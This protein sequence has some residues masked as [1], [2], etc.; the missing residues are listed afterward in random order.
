MGGFVIINMKTRYIFLICLFF[1]I[2]HG[3]P[4][5]ECVVEYIDG[6]LEMKQDNKWIEVEEGAILPLTAII[7]TH[8]NTLVELNLDQELYTISAKGIYNLHTIMTKSE[9]INSWNI[10]TMIEKK[11]ALMIEDDMTQYEATMGV[12][13]DETTDPDDIDWMESSEYTVWEGQ[14]LIDAGEYEKALEYFH[15]AFLNAFDENEEN[16]YLFYIGYCYALLG[17]KIHALISLSKIDI[18]EDV[19]Y[20][21]HFILIKSRLLAESL[22]FQKAL[23]L[24]GTYFKKFPKG[25]YAQAL[26]FLCAYCFTETN[27]RKEAITHLKRAYELDPHSPIGREAK[28][29]IKKLE[30]NPGSQE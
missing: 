10:G 6:I 29:Q 28:T 14:K 12:R 21:G 5:Q 13:G 25:E 19:S 23:D 8:D 3:I 24:T 11:L 2:I 20:Y 22:S 17:E 15:N 16:E 1:V 26:N 30:N 9:D 18:Q 4:A 7:Q 27:N